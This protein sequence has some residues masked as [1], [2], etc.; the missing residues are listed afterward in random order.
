MVWM[1]FISKSILWKDV[2]AYVHPVSQNKYCAVSSFII[3]DTNWIEPIKSIIISDLCN[4]RSSYISKI[5][6]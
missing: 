2:N 5:N 6:D 1:L 3:A 4:Y